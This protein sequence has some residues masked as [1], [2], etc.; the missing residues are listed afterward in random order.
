MSRDRTASPQDRVLPTDAEE[1]L[2]R[3]VGVE[4]HGWS[5]VLIEDQQ[6]RAYVVAAATGRMVQIPHGDA[7][8]LVERRTYRP[9]QGNRA[10]SPFGRLPLIAAAGSGEAPPPPADAAEPAFP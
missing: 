2:Y 6:G 4:P 8:A 7:M 9:W 1:T 3:V 5:T 10:W